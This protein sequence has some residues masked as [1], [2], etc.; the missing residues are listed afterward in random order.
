MN[1]ITVMG[2]IAGICTTSAFLPQVVKMFRTRKTEDIS[3][4]MYII[5]TTG[6]LL[7]IIYGSLNGD[8]PLVLANGITFIFASS[9][10]VLKLRH[11]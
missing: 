7:W 8:I 9:I 4:F 2:F 6:I 10:L 5:M 1:W 3:L 11:G